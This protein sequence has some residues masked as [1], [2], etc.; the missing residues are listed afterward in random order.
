MSW[1]GECLLFFDDIKDPEEI[2]SRVAETS[3]E[4]VHKAAMR[5]F[6]PMAFS[7][8]LVGPVDSEAI[9]GNW[10]RAMF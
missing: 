7:S 4:D 5:L 9:F 2:H 8:A 1:A 6:E 10:R 3:L